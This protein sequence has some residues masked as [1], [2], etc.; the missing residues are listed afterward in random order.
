MAARTAGSASVPPMPWR[1]RMVKGPLGEVAHQLH[2]D[3]AAD[4]GRH[5]AGD[6]AGA[7]RVGQGLGAGGE[8]AIDLAQDD[9]VVGVLDLHHARLGD[10]AGGVDDAAERALHADGAAHRIAR[11]NRRQ[12]ASVQRAAMAVEIPPGDAVHDEGDGGVGPEQ[13]R[14]GFRH[15]RQGGR[16]DGDDDGVLRAELGGAAGGNPH[17]EAAIRRLDGQALAADGV[18]LGA[19]GDDAGLGAA[20]G[21]PHR[22]M[23][24]DGAGAE[25]ADLHGL[26]FH[27]ARV[28]RSRAMRDSAST[29]AGMQ[30]SSGW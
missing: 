14:D 8:A 28:S 10:G 22:Q 29:P 3:L 9:A 15:L 6:A 19:A 4:R 24:A 18:E 2:P 30:P 16:L 13:R 20:T 21:Q 27:A 26:A 7:Q 11:I 23:A 1:E 25:H 5:L 12:A 17:L